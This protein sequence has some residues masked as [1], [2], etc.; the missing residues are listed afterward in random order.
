L[1]AIISGKTG[2]MTDFDPCNMA[3]E[4]LKIS[5]L[6][7]EKRLKM[8]ERCREQAKQFSIDVMAAKTRELYI[9]LGVKDANR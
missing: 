1:K 5:E 3:K 6:N 2:F 7:P 4:M 8:S 9:K